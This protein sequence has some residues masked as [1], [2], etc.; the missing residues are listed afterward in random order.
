MVKEDVCFYFPDII[1]T[2]VGIVLMIWANFYDSADGQLARM[3]GQ[4]TQ[5]GRILD[6]FA[7]EVNFFTIYVA[8][9]F[10]LMNEPMPFNIGMNW[11]LIIWVLTVC[12]G[13]LGHSNQCMLAD[14]YRNIHLYFLKGEGGS[15]LDNY[16]TQDELYRSIPWKGN[17]CQKFCLFFYR[18]YTHNQERATPAFQRFFSMV[19]EQYGGDIPRE[20]RDEFRSESKPLMKYTNILT[21]NT[22]AIALYISL[23]IGE[24]WL[25]IIFEIIVL[26]IIFIYMRNRHEAM[27][28]RLYAKYAGR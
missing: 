27:C 10:R 21:Y 1:H 4:K 24:P 16:K 25:Y 3:T 8:I 13:F 20:L 5:I 2:L 28:T 9:S 22:R 23:L 26:S 14:Y 12:N 7:G 15:E 17:F 19:N 18:N 11:G 6:G